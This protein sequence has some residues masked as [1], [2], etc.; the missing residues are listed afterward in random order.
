MCRGC[1]L[2]VISRLSQPVLPPAPMFCIDFG[3]RDC[4]DGGVGWRE[5]E[6]IRK[7]SKAP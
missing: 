7:S 6:N 3:G 2:F 1:N 5:L 4:P